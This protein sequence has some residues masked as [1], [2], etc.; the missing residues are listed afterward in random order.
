MWTSGFR[1]GKD[2]GSWGRKG[3]GGKGMN[4]WI[5]R[6]E[7]LFFSWWKDLMVKR[8]LK[9]LPFGFLSSGKMEKLKS[10]S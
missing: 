10:G 7:K 1:K 6:S 3:E 5:K 2:K 8:Y 4:Q 9:S